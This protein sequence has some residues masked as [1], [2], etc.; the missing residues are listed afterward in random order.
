VDAVRKEMQQLHD[1]KV[2]KPVEHKGLTASQKREALEYLM[3]LKRKRCGKIKGRGCADG[4]KQRAYTAKE[5]AASPTIA[6]EALFL[7]AIIGA[8]EDREVA[9]VDVPGA[10]M[11]ADMDELV[12]VRFTGK[13]VDLLLEIDKE[14][15][16]PYLTMERGER[17][18]YVELLKALYGTLRAAR[19]FWEKLSSKLIEWGFKRNPYDP[20]VMNKTV[21]GKQLTV[22]WHVDD[23]IT[24]HVDKIVVDHFIEQLEGEFGKE[25]PMNVSRGKV[26]D[27]LGMVLDFSKPGELIVNMVDYVKNILHNAPDDME[28]VTKTPAASHLFDVAS[29]DDSVPLNEE[30][31]SAFVTLTMQSLYLSQRARPDIRTAVSFL[32]SRLK[33][34]D[35]DDYKKLTRVIKY[36]RRTVDMVL[37]LSADG[38]GEV[39][40]YVDALFAVHP[41]MKGHTGGTLSLGKGSAYSTSVRQKLVTRSSTESEV[42]GVHDV[43]PQVIWTGYFLKAQGFEVRD[44]KLYQDNMSAMLLEKNGKS[45]STKRTRHMNIRYFFI[46]DRVASKEVTIEHCP[47]ADM[48][49][50][51]FTKPLQGGPFG[52][53]RNLVMNLD[54]SSPYY[55]VQRSVLS[56]P[57]NGDVDSDVEVGAESAV[58]KVRWADEADDG[59]S[60]LEVNQ[61]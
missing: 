25:T 28:G 47:T 3:F 31:R 50:D 58:K 26:H 22:G 6:T 51:F 8:L 37:T 43:L 1:R 11:Q 41:D 49:A 44:T 23:I 52:K 60:L 16:E 30:K 29:D 45:S 24:L 35:E 46:K 57:E 4:R 12:H 18:M 21:N 19:L 20:C 61:L 13:M 36:L 48:I 54:R 5:D 33:N 59:R 32:T 39:K 55:S 42:V 56:D 34:P 17:V 15:Y 9:V 2:M 38:S 53:L 27:Y 7:I 14:M 10:F 40:W